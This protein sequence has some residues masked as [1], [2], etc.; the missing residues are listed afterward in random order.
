M[1]KC[2]KC[3]T[4]PATIHDLCWWCSQ[5]GREETRDNLMELQLLERP[6]VT[7]DPLDHRRSDP[8]ALA[9]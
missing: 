8:H 9:L 6:R 7:F 4:R 3:R 1:K 2:K 5:V